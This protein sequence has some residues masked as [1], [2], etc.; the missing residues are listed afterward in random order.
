MTSAKISI[1]RLSGLAEIWLLIRSPD[2][3]TGIWRGLAG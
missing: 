2:R 3:R 1:R